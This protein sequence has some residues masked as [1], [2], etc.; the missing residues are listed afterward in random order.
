[1][2]EQAAN[3]GVVRGIG[4]P[5]FADVEALTTSYSEV[6]YALRRQSPR[7]TWAAIIGNIQITPAQILD[8]E[9]I[10][11][12]MAG[13]GNYQ[14]D[15]YEPVTK[16]PLLLFTL[17]LEG[18][19][20][21]VPPAAMSAGPPTAYGQAPAY[22]PPTIASMTP[23]PPQ[24]GALPPPPPGLTWMQTPHGMV[25]VQQSAVAAMQPGPQ[26]AP[27]T[28]IPSDEM[29]LR[30]VAART[31]EIAELKKEIATLQAKIDSE[32]ERAADKYTVL[33]D[34]HNDYVEA[35][36]ERERKLENERTEARMEARIAAATKS[37]SGE[38]SL[39]GFAKLAAALAPIATGMMSNS[40]EQA[41]AAAQ[42]QTALI[43]NALKPREDATGAALLMKLL[44]QK[45]PKHQIDAMDAAAQSQMAMFGMMSQIVNMVQQTQPPDSPMMM[46]LNQMLVGAGQLV[47]KWV[48]KSNG[49][50]AI[51]TQ[52]EPV[53]PP[54]IRAPA[55]PQAPAPAQQTA[56]AAAEPQPAP[57]NGA[58]PS[59]TVPPSATYSTQGDEEEGDEDGDEETPAA[60][61]QNGAA[62]A[63][64]APTQNQIA[65]QVVSEFLAQPQIPASFKT[66]EWRDLIFRIHMMLD[67][68]AV[69]AKFVTLL[70]RLKRTNTVP[71]VLADVFTNPEERIT[72]IVGALPIIRMN[73]DYATALRDRVVDTL[74]ADANGA[75]ATATT[76]N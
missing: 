60:A 64:P 50:Q 62:A 71:P 55:Q 49:D 38:S 13:G 65:Q 11:R 61:P 22:G 8:M 57:T 5:A 30:E 36:K 15:V 2:A 52:G 56:Q 28:S 69:A 1:M 68:D 6:Q 7:G 48:N 25:L 33:Q 40:K 31:K 37:N 75:P 16:K 23:P 59:F 44:D 45:D 14:V 53:L 24:A 10:V 4:L 46:L 72:S 19:P 20:K 35:A 12:D 43:T 70:R 66:Q 42:T 3:G 67:V 27:R 9:T 29:A 73:V 32:R 63:P 74:I 18:P 17:S 76:P 51:Q 41:I 47:D 21:V 34:K 39:D 26:E 58:A 54:R